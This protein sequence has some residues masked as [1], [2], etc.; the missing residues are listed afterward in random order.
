MNLPDF[1]L[2]SGYATQTVTVRD[3]VTHRTGL[4]RHDLVMVHS[5]L[6]R[7]QLIKRLRHLE[8]STEPPRARFQYNN[9]IWPERNS[10]QY[11][12]GWVVSNYRGVTLVDHGSNLTGA[13]TALDFVP[14]RNVGVYATV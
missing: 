4:P 1:R 12:M 6:S 2:H 11:G 9:L 7:E 10:L 5:P 13:S 8:L 3:L 14:G